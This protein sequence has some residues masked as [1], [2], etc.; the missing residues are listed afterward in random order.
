MS[1]PPDGF[2]IR[3]CPGCDLWCASNYIYSCTYSCEKDV[4]YPIYN[5]YPLYV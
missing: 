2:E 3:P 4:V 1:D 5:E